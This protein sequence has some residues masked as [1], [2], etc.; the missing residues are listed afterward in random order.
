MHQSYEIQIPVQVKERFG[1]PSFWV[2]TRL[3]ARRIRPIPIRL[4]VDT[5]SPWTA[6]APRDWKL[7]GLIPRILNK[8]TKYPRIGYAGYNFERYVMTNAKLRFKNRTG[9]IITIIVP[10]LSILVPT[11]K[12]PKLVEDKIDSVLGMDI[13][14]PPIFDEKT[15]EWFIVPWE[16]IKVE[17]SS[18]T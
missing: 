12:I 11:G 14:T 7:L 8:A 2:Y 4:L 17:V 16:N 9:G 10:E 1:A 5:G 6:L 13:C 15:K 3:V 18:I